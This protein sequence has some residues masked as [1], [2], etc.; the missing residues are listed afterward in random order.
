MCRT[1]VKKFNFVEHPNAE[2]LLQ[3]LKL[4]VDLFEVMC[5]LENNL[6]LM[7]YREQLVELRGLPVLGRAGQQPV[8]CGDA[9]SH[10]PIVT[11]REFFV[12]HSTFARFHVE[13][14]RRR[15]YTP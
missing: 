4:T 6:D 8:G 14:W 7:L 9:R 10:N 2:G 15:D 12:D 3:Q 11:Q 5:G 13:I 1:F